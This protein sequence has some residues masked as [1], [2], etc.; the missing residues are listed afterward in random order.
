MSIKNTAIKDKR[1]FETEVYELT[2]N[3]IVNSK[4]RTRCLD[5]VTWLRSETISKFFSVSE[6]SKTIS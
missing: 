6:I 3:V 2:W 4:Y 5:K 1:V